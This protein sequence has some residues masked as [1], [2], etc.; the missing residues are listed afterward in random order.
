MYPHDTLVLRATGIV[1]APTE[2]R[3]SFDNG[4]LT[5]SCHHH[6]FREPPTKAPSASAEKEQAHSQFTYLCGEPQRR[7]SLRFSFSECTQ[8]SDFTRRNKRKQN[9]TNFAFKASPYLSMAPNPFL[10][11]FLS[12]SSFSSF[13]FF[14]LTFTLPFSFFFSF[15]FV[16]LTFLALFSTSSSSAFPWGADSQFGAPWPEWELLSDR[17]SVQ[18]EREKKINTHGQGHLLLVYQEKLKCKTQKN[19]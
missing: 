5:A 14:S 16:F 15:S 4:F 12:G 6:E 17:P 7:E 3:P 10:F 19:E 13:C 11:I 8:M 18:R 1:H 2:P 9:K